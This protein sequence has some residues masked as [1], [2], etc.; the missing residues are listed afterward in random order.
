MVRVVTCLM[1]GMQG[2]GLNCRL[3]LGSKVLSVL[4]TSRGSGKLLRTAYVSMWSSPVKPERELQAQKP[5]HTYRHT[6]QVILYSVPSNVLY[7]TDNS[8][9]TLSSSSSSISST[10]INERLSTCKSS[11]DCRHVQW[12]LTIL[13]LQWSMYTLTP[14]ITANKLLH[15]TISSFNSQLI[16]CR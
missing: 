9:V 5:V 11:V 16:I 6:L 10:I 1:S 14:Q 15:N 13:C 12:R 8:T 2:G 3:H 7:W 4:H